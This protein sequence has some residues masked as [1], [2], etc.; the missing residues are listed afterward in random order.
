M[1]PHIPDGS[2]CV[3]RRPGA[4]RDGG[5]VLVERHVAEDPERGGRYVVKEYRNRDARPQ[6]MSANP[7]YAPLEV[8]EADRIVAEW[9]EVVEPVSDMA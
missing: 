9:V 4:L 2:W 5:W 7:D 3:F 1:E 8:T 6:L